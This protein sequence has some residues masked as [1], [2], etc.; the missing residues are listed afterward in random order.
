MHLVHVR[1][2][3]RL[4]AEL[5][6]QTP[7]KLPGNIDL[8]W[9]NFF[10]QDLY[11]GDGF[12]KAIDKYGT[13]FANKVLGDFRVV[14]ANPQ[15]VKQ[16]LA[17]D[18]H[19][20]EKGPKFNKIVG[21][22]LGVGVFNS[23]GE[24]WQFH[25][26]LTRPFFARERVTDFGIFDTKA[27]IAIQKMQERF[28]QG[29]AIDFQDI[30]SRFTIDS[31][32]EFLLNASIHSLQD[33]LPRSG[34][35]F[36]D[37]ATPSNRFARAF[38]N[39]QISISKRAR[40]GVAWPLFEIF[41]DRTADDMKEVRGFIEPIVRE[42]MRKRANGFESKRDESLLQHLLDVTENMTLIVDEIIN[43]LL[44]GRDTTAGLLT[45]VAYCLS[46]H[47]D[48]LARLREEIL[49][50]VGTSRAPTFD[51]VRGMKYLRA[52]LNETLRLFPSVPFNSRAT[53]QATTIVSDEG[54]KLYVPANTRVTF[55]TMLSQR[56]KPYWGEDAHLFD[57][58]RF[59]DDRLKKHITNNPYVFVPFSAGPRICLGQQF[60][61][62]EAS[63][64]II[65]MLQ[66]FDRIELAP[67]CQPESSQPPASW[68]HSNS[69]TPR[70]AF[71]QCV[72]NS[73]LTLYS[74]GGLW[75]RM[76]QSKATEG[77]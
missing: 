52:V 14:T 71:E 44:A 73:H 65:R 68:K 66:H 37:I 59:L 9:T 28:D 25:R 1:D 18:F 4:G 24:M 49:S 77:V 42:A 11:L 47:P 15:N 35:D 8:L 61:Y 17:T 12:A 45:F 2:A 40:I 41:K 43:I 75:L 5:I 3:R 53:I 63:F 30:C 27:S 32:C 72:L 22:V 67:D 7:G 10:G 54:R 16:L 50:T 70:K 48:V 20:Y 51:D 58:D 62:H 31:A 46:M 57:P 38:A 60:A 76:S 19:S 6:V 74:E 29:Q 55:A 56:H 13:T 64:F 33:P 36:S 39:A 69:G 34:E 23:D 26:K 21:S